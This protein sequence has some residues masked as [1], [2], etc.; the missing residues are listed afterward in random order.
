MLSGY[1][2]FNPTKTLLRIQTENGT[3]LVKSND[4]L[5]VWDQ[6]IIKVWEC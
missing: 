1:F 2:V 4:Y 6:Q 3:Q 5:W